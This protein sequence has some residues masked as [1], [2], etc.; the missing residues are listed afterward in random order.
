MTVAPNLWKAIGYEPHPKQMEFH[1]SGARFK[2]AV[3]GRRFGKSRMAAAE[4][5]PRLLGAEP[6]RGWIVGP[7]YKTGEKEF[8]YIWQDL[9]LTMKLKQL[10]LVKRAA[11]NMRTGEMYIEMKNGSRVDVMSAEHADGLVGEGLHWVIV[12]EAAK[13]N[14]Q[15]WDKYIRPAL[16]DYKGTA[17]FPSTPEGFNWYY[18]AYKRGQDKREP[19]WDSWRY[20]S[21][22]N[23][24]VYPG[25]FEDA[26]IQGQLRTPDDPHFWQ[27][28]GAD[29]RSVVGLIYPE[30]SQEKHVR[31]VEY[32]PDLPVDI[33][34][35]PGFANAFAGLYIQQS[36]MDDLYV[37]GEHYE[38]QKTRYQN[39]GLM[40]EH[41]DK[42]GWNVRCA[43][44]DQA[45]PDT[46][47]TFREIMGVPAV[48]MEEAKAWS[49]GCDAVKD[50]LAA[51]G[52]G[53]A[54]LF[55]DNS[56]LNFIREIEAYK[57]KQP[58][59]G[60]DPL[61]NLKEEAHK[62]DDHLMDAL[63]YYVMHKFVLGADAHL[64]EDMVMSPAVVPDMPRDFDIDEVGVGDTIFSWSGLG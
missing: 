6:T 60:R 33:A 15:I 45:D 56:C 8:R 21:W 51:P 36:P 1:E 58:A 57:T 47:A 61:E 41:V 12:A 53:D 62:K 37:I 10:G 29:F 18:E 16:A 17:I 11:Y 46:A 54:R 13:Q 27:E 14:P 25:G 50:F 44:G 9:I 20:P 40:K 55:V 39:V 34:Y 64:D 22:M 28:I 5:E 3:C 7:E 42:M 49:Q 30:W 52:S 23:P 38:R 43:Y 2:V 31:I 19:E 24:H 63:R 4:V 32:N 26:E 48:A 59:R 35:D